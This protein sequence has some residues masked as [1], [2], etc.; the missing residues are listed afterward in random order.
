[1][2]RWAVRIMFV[3]LVVSVGVNGVLVGRYVIPRQNPPSSLDSCTPIPLGLIPAPYNRS[4][5][6]QYLNGSYVLYS[7]KT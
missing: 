3:V 4:I 2:N 5:P 1:M 7:C 6:E